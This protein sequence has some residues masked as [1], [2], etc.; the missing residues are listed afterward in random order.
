M[1]GAMSA[2]RLPFTATRLAHV[3]PGTALGTL[4][5]LI[6]VIGAGLAMLPKGPPGGAA[7]SGDAALYRQ[8]AARVTNGEAYYSAAAA[9][10]RASAYPLKPFTAVRQPLLAEI[11]ATIGPAGTELLLR[12]LA[13]AAAAATATRLA[14][15]LKTPFR[16]IAILL[17]AASAGAFVQHGMWVW[18]EIWAGLLITL[19]L[20]SRTERHWLLSVAFG[21]S[22]ALLR[23]LA[24]PFLLV[25][26]GT[27][28]AGGNRREAG[29]WIVAV[30]IALTALAL[31][32]ISV[33]AITRPTDVTSPGWIVFGGWR[34]DLTLARSSV[35]LLLPPWVAA[36]M[37][38]LALLGWCACRGAYA[39]RT[40]AMLGMWM[41]AFLI[42]GRP[43]NSYWGFLFAPLLPVGLALAP[44]ALWD[45]VRASRPLIA[46]AGATAIRS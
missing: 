1:I 4:L 26:A 6:L 24:F 45:L 27:A 40:A 17:S 12:L 21:L 13:V 22:A 34:F 33:G 23:E 5:A 32:M 25:M 44:A 11:A 15:A 7:S 29:A 37:T 28:W 8:I 41:T 9:E 19:A 10:H 3:S 43:D 35:L 18:H 46:P 38:P 2:D 14:P 39:L 16:E 20:A 36:V 31:H 42:V 30:A